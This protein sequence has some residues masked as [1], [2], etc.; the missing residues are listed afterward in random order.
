MLQTAAQGAHQTCPEMTYKIQPSLWLHQAQSMF[1]EV[2]LQSGPRISLVTFQL[3]SLS[4]SLNC[5]HTNEWQLYNL[6]RNQVLLK[7]SHIW[8]IKVGAPVRSCWQNRFTRCTFEEKKP[9]RGWKKQTTKYS[10]LPNNDI[11]YI[12]SA[13]QHRFKKKAL[14]FL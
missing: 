4:V 3:M 2:F 10:Q 9:L 14:S 7:L 6:T 8:N 11:V 13:V 1:L 12:P 5:M